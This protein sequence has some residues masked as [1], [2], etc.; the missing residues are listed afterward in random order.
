ME[1]TLN[2][3]LE[4][5]KRTLF[6]PLFNNF[7][8]YNDG[9]CYRIFT[10]ELAD[11]FDE[12]Q[13][14]YFSNDYQSRIGQHYFSS[15]YDDYISEEMLLEV[16]KADEHEFFEGLKVYFA[17]FDSMDT[18]ISDIVNNYVTKVDFMPELFVLV[19]LQIMNEEK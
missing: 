12:Y 8:K 15:L 1:N 19:T 7:L 13:P 18:H 16:I 11:L 5:L 10:K 4:Y 14:E 6:V 2:Q 17:S 3:T 9:R